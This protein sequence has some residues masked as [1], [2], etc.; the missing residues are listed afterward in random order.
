MKAVTRAWA[1]MAVAACSMPGFAQDENA[2]EQAQL[3]ETGDAATPTETAQAE[4]APAETPSDETPPD[5]AA[6]V[7][8]IPVET[9]APPAPEATELEAVTVT[10]QKRVQRLTD[11]P[12][13][14][15]AVSRDDIR[16]T[17]IEQVRDLA[18]YIT[19]VDIKEQVPG[20]I[21][22]VTIRGVG[23]DDFSSTNSPAAGIYVDQVTLSSLALM[24][25]DLFDI[26]RIEALKGPQGTLYG[27]N[28]TAGA[29]NVLTAG[30]E[31][32]RS[33]YVKAGY[34]D[35]KTTDLEGMFNQP[36]GETFALRIAGKFV[37]QDDGFWES[38]SG[39]D[40]AYAGPST[41]YTSSDPV[42]RR[43]GA[44]DVKAGR[45][46]LA[47]QPVETVK[48]DLKY[49][50]LRQRS[51][52]GQPEMFG[53]APRP[54]GSGTC[55]PI[56]PANCGDA[57]GYSDDDFDPYVGH[58]RG[59]FPYDI[60]QTG[61]TL[62]AEW[63]LGWATL[64]GVSGHMDFERYFHIDVDGTPADEFDFFQRDTVDQVTHE[65]RLAGTAGLGDWLLGAFYG[66]DTIVIDT[67]GRHQDLIPGEASQIDADQDTES[68]ALFANMDWQ[69]GR[70]VA[71]LEDFTL[72]TGLRYTDESRDYVGGTTWT[73]TIP[74]TL[75]NTFEDSSISDKNWSWKAGLNWKPTG[76]QLVFANVSKGVKSGGYFA[77]VTN[78][79]NQLEP[80]APEELTAY[81]VG[82][83]LGGTLAVN[84]SAFFYDYR[85][86]QTFMRANGAAAQYIGN[87]AE[88]ETK[89]LDFEVSWRGIDGLTLAGGFGILDTW[90][91]SF[92]GP[93]DADMDG[94]GDPV[95]EGNKLP[96]SPE[97]TWLGKVR[98]ELPLGGWLAAAQAD[99]HYSDE[100]YKEATNDPLIKSG[101]YT[102][103]NGRLA[104]MPGER[105]WELAL[106]GRNLTDEQY[107][108]QGADI[109]AFFVG[110]R[111]YNAPRT[112]GAELTWTFQ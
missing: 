6:P 111:N 101:E 77:G 30:P 18:G 63:D 97:L 69:L 22:V 57:L 28:S 15:S 51:E 27:R 11:V 58:W 37:E 68:T 85:D 93:A 12:I 64:N 96:N 53:T 17:R 3:W 89:G 31:W 75:D 21:P 41:N 7:E 44:R 10:A 35:Y 67:A 91:G 54:G 106:W 73:V 42:V 33:A 24:S 74:G 94:N 23:L 86:K 8:T 5:A 83:K 65:L 81:E 52:M 45:A 20:A 100:T 72:T 16:S 90:M 4:A 71:A 110:N 70:F 39:A 34:G 98:Y 99:A 60:D 2:G 103:V 25:F 62:L 1:F 9:A 26:E 82:Y 108:V 112:V 84:T 40:E 46:R 32:D 88:A 76:R 92:I 109:S 14:V 102:V 36:F 95:P 80:Y 105:T 19:N 66:E 87:V 55:V 56:D 29:I 47:W 50:T 38:R 48:L 61:E 59:E 43:V 104:F 13:N 79:Q 78:D 107:V 49:E